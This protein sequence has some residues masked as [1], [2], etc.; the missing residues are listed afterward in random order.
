MAQ[1]TAPIVIAGAVE[2]PGDEAVFHR[3]IAAVGATSGPV[4]GKNGKERLRSQILGYNHAAQH[5]PWC[6]LVDL[7]Q[8]ATCAAALR[9]LWL[10][11]PAPGMCFR[12][13]VR[14]IESWLL[15]DRARMAQ[16]L[17]VREAIVPEWPDALDDPKQA[18]INLAR[19]SR[20]RAIVEDMVP[21]P[22]SGRS[23]GRGYTSR[24]ID[25]ASDLSDNGWR[26]KVAAQHSD[27]LR[28]CL[29]AL[30]RLV[31]RHHGTTIEA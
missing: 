16:F 2:G 12:V 4:H 9:D 24:V 19:R 27:S 18:L 20:R 5:A 22:R 14:K 1:P 21:G 15:A 28:R 10:P 7:N 13:V 6:V 30:D 17:G 26:P 25:F 11:T 31:Q 3:L 8:S 29:A 23:V